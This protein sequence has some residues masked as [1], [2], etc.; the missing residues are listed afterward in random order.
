MSW[1]RLKSSQQG[2]NTSYSGSTRVL[3]IDVLHS[4]WSIL[5]RSRRHFHLR[6][7][8]S[9]RFPPPRQWQ[10]SLRRTLDTALLLMKNVHFGLVDYGGESVIGT[11]EKSRRQVARCRERKVNLMCSK[12]IHKELIIILKP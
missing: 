11:I 12:A 8:L 2:D 1:Q 10:N 3:Q 6:V 7:A 5:S 4:D 9:Q